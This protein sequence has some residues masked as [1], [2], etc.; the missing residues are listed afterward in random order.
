MVPETEAQTTRFDRTPRQNR[1][2]AQPLGQHVDQKTADS[3]AESNAEILPEIAAR[4]AS[5]GYQFIDKERLVATFLTN[6]THMHTKT[7]HWYGS[8]VPFCWFLSVFTSKTM[9]ITFR[10]PSLL[11]NLL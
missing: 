10:V 5:K 11:F 6:N 3:A 8:M 4:R 1:D 7:L 9:R 2:G